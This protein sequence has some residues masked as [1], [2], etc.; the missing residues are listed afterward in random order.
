MGNFPSVPGLSDNILLQVTDCFRHGRD[1]TK[2]APVANDCDSAVCF[3]GCYIRHLCCPKENSTTATSP[4]GLRPTSG[5]WTTRATLEGGPRILRT[6][7]PFRSGRFRQA[8]S[9]R[10]IPR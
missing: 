5:L 1:I 8:L 3:G 9:T 4:A 7:V 10:E 2:G 6:K